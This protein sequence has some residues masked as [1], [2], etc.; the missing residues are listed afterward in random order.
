M[1]V[2]AMKRKLNEDDVSAVIETIDPP[3]TTTT[4]T[5]TT[6]MGSSSSFNALGLDSRLLQAVAKENFSSPT[7]VQARAIPLA[8]EG[9]DILARSKTGS[10]KTAAYVLPILQSI[11]HR[12]S[13]REDSS[14][15]LIAADP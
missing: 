9:K 14:R 2:A 1:V 15:F 5:T 6:T 7:Q 4:K 11:L 8:L 3:T 10:G 13:V 12:K